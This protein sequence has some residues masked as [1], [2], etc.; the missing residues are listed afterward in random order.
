MEPDLLQLVRHFGDAGLAAGLFLLPAVRGPA[1]ADA[2]DR[3]FADFDRNAALERNDLGKRPLAG[4]VGLGAL[5]PFDGSP[6]ESPRRIGLAAGELD[7]MR[8]RPIA[9]EENSQPA[10]AIDDGNR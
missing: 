8:R 2:A 4:D 1:Q 7:I 3:I 6:P 9:L 10:C 5:R